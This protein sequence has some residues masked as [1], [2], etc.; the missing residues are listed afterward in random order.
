MLKRTVRK[1]STKLLPLY[2]RP[3]NV[4]THGQGCYLVDK[5]E[6]KFL[7]FTAGIAVNALGHGDLQIAEIIHDQ[8]KKLIHLSN[9][10]HNEYAEGL[11]EMMVDSLQGTS[12]NDSQV[13]FCNSGTEANEGA[14]KFAR[15]YARTVYPNEP[16]RFKIVSFKNAF[17]GRTLAAL[18]A[19]PNKKYQTP[20][21][22]LMQG[23]YTLDFN[24]VDS[25]SEIDKDVCAVI[26]EPIQGEGGINIATDEFM[27]AL[28]E[29]CDETGALL[30]FDEIQCGMGRTGKLFGFQN[31]NVEPDLLTMAKPMANGLPLGA[32]VVG[33]RVAKTISPGDHG[34]T[35]GG[36]PLATRVG[37]HVWKRI[38]DPNFLSNV[39]KIGEFLYQECANLAKVSPLIQSVR[40]KGLMVGFTLRENVPTSMFVDLCLERGVL[41]VS[42]GNNTI[43]LVPPLIMTEEEIKKG[44]VVFERVLT[45]MEGRIASG[46]K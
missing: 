24:N 1:Y 9:L 30:I 35:F 41:V 23:F 27:T 31:Y 10:Y 2:G 36:S 26:V 12:L 3:A 43:R 5:N 22:P 17:H 32:V 6:K 42:A 7:D 19:T 39:S 18:S 25:L 21:F 16:T 33:N 44:I 37:Q 20:F 15:K 46:K 4:F 45:I 40:G 14:F 38:S 28:R 8:A 29:R 11:A 34:T 13:F